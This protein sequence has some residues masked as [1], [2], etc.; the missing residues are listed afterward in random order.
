MTDT[1]IIV[2]TDSLAPY[3]KAPIDSG[4][5]A[6]VFPCADW[7]RDLSPWPA[8]KVFRKGEDFAGGASEYLDRLLGFSKSWEDSLSCPIRRRYLAGYSLAGLFCLWALTNTDRFDGAAS[9]SGSLWYP[10]WTDYAK[11]H[12][13]LKADARISLSLGDQ[14]AHTRNPLMAAVADCTLACEHLYRTQGAYV[15]FRWN[16][17]NHFQDTEARTWEAAMRLLNTEPSTEPSL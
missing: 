14:E 11:S 4:F 8:Q 2:G 6:A 1:L 5:A 12:P 9:A 13:P 7:N 17:G 10:G 15:T 16:P 3:P